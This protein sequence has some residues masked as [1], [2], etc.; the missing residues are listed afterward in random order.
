MPP[1]IAPPTSPMKST[2]GIMI[3]D[4][5]SGTVSAVMVDSSPPAMIWPSPPMFMTLARKATQMPVPTSSSGIAL[6]ADSANSSVPP[7][8]PLSSSL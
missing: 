2:S 8:A 1:Q 4:G 5:R 3:I 7:K 6:A